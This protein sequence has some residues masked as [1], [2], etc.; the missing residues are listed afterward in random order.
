MPKTNSLN[1]RIQLKIDTEAHWN[2]A[3]NFKPLKGEIIIY[4]ADT[5][6]R[7]SRLK[8]GDG[9][10][11]VS[12]LPFI[13][14]GT[15][16]G[17]VIED[18]VQ[19]YTSKQLFPVTG[20]INSVYIN[21]ADSQIYCWNPNN[22][23]T[24]V[25]GESYTFESG[26][27]SFSVT[28][29]IG[30]P[31]IVNVTPYIPHNITGGG[32]ADY[33]VK[34]DGANTIT[35]LVPLRT[36]SSQDENIR[37]LREDG[38]WG[39]P[40]ITSSNRVTQR[41]QGSNN[42]YYSPLFKWSANTSEE[43]NYVRFSNTSKI[44]INPVNNRIRANGFQIA[45]TD[46]NTGLFPYANGQNTIGSP[47]IQW[48]SA[49]VSHYFGET[50]DVR[51]WRGQNGECNVGTRASDSSDAIRGAIN[52]FNE[53]D[54][55]EEQSY[56]TLEA[57]ENASREQNTVIRLPASGG[58][59]ADGLLLLA[60][61]S[62]VLPNTIWNIG[63]SGQAASAI[64][65][66]E[67]NII[68]DTFLKRSGGT[69]TGKLVLDGDP[70][71]PLHAATKR[72]VDNIIS[73]NSTMVFKGT[74][75]DFTTNA[76]ISILPD[77]HNAGW[78]YAV[79]S[80]GYYA[81][82]NCY[83]GDLIICVN[84]GEY[85]SDS[86]W[87]VISTHLNEIESANFD[88]SYLKLNGS[89][90][91]T[92]TIKVNNTN[93]II[94]NSSNRTLKI[95]EVVGRNAGFSNNAYGFY[96]QYNHNGDL[97]ELYT[98][99]NLSL[100]VKVRSINQAGMVT[101]HTDTV[102]SRPIQGSI[103]G[104]AATATT[105]TYLNNFKTTTNSNL[106]LNP[107]T[108]Y[109]AI[110]YINGFAAED[111]NYQQVDG[112]LY[113]QMFDVDTAS[114]IFQD[115]RSGSL[116]VRGKNGGIWTS[117]RRILDENNFAEISG[118]GS[119][120][121]SNVTDFAP[122]NRGVPTPETADNLTFL[123]NDN[124]WYQL[125][126][127]DLSNLL[128]NFTVSSGNANAGDM[129]LTL[130][131]NGTYHYR[132]IANIITK[133][134]IDT[135]LGTSSTQTDKFYR[136]DGTWSIPVYPVSSVAG[137]TGNIDAAALRSA[138][139]LG[140]VLH[141]I[142]LTTTRMYDG[143]QGVGSDRTGAVIINNVSTK[144][145]IGDVVLDDT[146]NLEF[147]WTGSIWEQ[148]GNDT[149][150]KQIAAQPFDYTLAENSN[151]W[152][153]GI[154]QNINGDITSI[155]EGTLVTTGL[156][157]GTAN[158]A[159]TATKAINDKN[160]NDITETYLRKTG[161]STAG[162]LVLIGSNARRLLWKDS[163]DAQ[164]YEAITIQNQTTGTPDADA[165]L[166]NFKHSINQGTTW[167][168][169]VTIY[170]D[171]SISG[172]R[173][174]GVASSAISAD[175]WTNDRK[176]YVNLELSSTNTLLNGSSNINAAPIG[177][178]IDGILPIEHGGTGAQSM[179]ELR[180]ALGLTQAMRF[181]GITTT[182]LSDGDATAFIDLRD[183]P[184]SVQATVGDI[185]IDNLT[186]AEYIWTIDNKWERLG[187][188][189]AWA[190]DAEVIHNNLL[191]DAGD[192]IYGGLQDNKIIPM[193][194]SIPVAAYGYVLTV[195]LQ[196]GTFVPVWSTSTNITSVGTITAG[197]WHGNVIDTEYGGTGTA[198]YTNLN[199]LLYVTE[200]TETN[201]VVYKS[202][203]M[204]TD[205][206]SIMNLGSITIGAARTQYINNTNNIYNLYVAGNTFLENLRLG[207][208]NTYGS[209]YQPVYWNDGIPTP[210][211]TLQKKTF[212]FSEVNGQD[213]T[214]S[215]HH[216][217][218]YTKN[219]IVVSIVVTQ[220]EQYLLTP[221]QWEA[222]NGEIQLTASKLNG[223]IKGYIL[224]AAGADLDEEG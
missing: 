76:T 143:M 110:G 111:W 153:R 21:L 10:N 30:S 98:D 195:G 106:G 33:L 34:F 161:D 47:V 57:N 207:E 138:L 154:H 216:A 52:F 130:F 181:L 192:I 72:Y 89:N 64:R 7:F 136:G 176:V 221:I 121:Y 50:S 187:R 42:T 157:E 149:S 201:K 169:L 29:S 156:W 224:T 107:T 148:L 152:I 197:T 15:T 1:T 145:E 48:N 39:I 71:Y 94:I 87:S 88:S 165:A 97:L 36:I 123:R 120:A 175:T 108:V 23:Y 191:L 55:G 205:G 49:Y 77:Q 128:D 37:Y 135:A 188:D 140:S 141:F 119:A 213:I 84:S 170:A 79:L 206:N 125:T 158:I 8:V 173:F 142:G 69:M 105:A 159:N 116:S 90:I 115:Y 223:V 160:N 28:P 82:Q 193:R 31:Y 14:A 61:G 62:N 200:D 189:N 177:I 164:Q 162:A 202:G 5:S 27:N 99:N 155:D 179:A 59:T 124:S 16:N 174:L 104:N 212:N 12:D 101:F 40:S 102:F 127:Q 186:N 83:P 74:I 24:R 178:G 17:R 26:T 4:S 109:A 163:N 114:Q 209:L 137:L 185:V 93:G 56:T 198:T 219:T 66:T 100:N 20:D 122:A 46:N 92:G 91:M 208:E 144:P 147:L 54:T 9:I 220:G 67:G 166:F 60:D 103:T 41:P 132:S 218:A 126:A 129:I 68:K 78:T 131:T 112:A 215:L 22:G 25:G 70:L 73:A 51:D 80:E 168:N 32:D 38:N 150:Y 214:I 184:I 134:L 133:P 95:W 211:A 118:I 63:I 45:S 35:N 43:T 65:D 96:E 3:E 199:S 53:C 44:G 2:L 18:V 58:E 6:R 81:G 217:A 11:Y 182:N 204:L 86:D 190:L 194:R 117:W 13:D 139:S 113:Q 196:N 203:T 222:F 151:R 172:N 85:D 180:T 146:S 171:G 167:S 210:V 19:V 75:G 183:N